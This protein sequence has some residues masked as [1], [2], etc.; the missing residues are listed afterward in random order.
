MIINLLTPQVAV[1]RTAYASRGGIKS[2]GIFC[3]ATES[4]PP[5]ALA[6]LGTHKI[7]DSGNSDA[8]RARYLTEYH[9]T[10][11]NCSNLVIKNG[12]LRPFVRGS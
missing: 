4:N 8:V 9:L 6:R 7:Y 2:K 5:K 11:V 1:S 12:T 10:Q 3:H